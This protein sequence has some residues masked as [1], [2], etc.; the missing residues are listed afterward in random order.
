MGDE[1][2]VHLS[3]RKKKLKCVPSAGKIMAAVS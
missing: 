1:T 2:F 3:H